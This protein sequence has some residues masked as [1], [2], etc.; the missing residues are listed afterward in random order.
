MQQQEPA[1]PPPPPEDEAL[2]VDYR[3]WASGAEVEVGR[4]LGR[5]SVQGAGLWVV[6]A[7]GGAGTSTWAGLL[8][9]GDAGRAW[10]VSAQRLR[11]LVAAR[12]SAAGLEAAR[13][14]AVEWVEGTLPHIE[15]VG[16]L[17]GAD[18]PGRRLPKA[19]QALVA[20]I[21]GAFPI[22]LR[23]PWQASWR[24]AIEPEVAAK[25]LRVRR[26]IRTVQ[27]INSEDQL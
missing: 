11:V 10:P 25:S 23:V 15:L 26:I 8:E 20:D 2:E 13:A 18:A 22:V 1:A 6:G 17:L 5:I 4:R 12:S 24:T 19:L 27:K 14:A 16:L 7:H 3:P 9:A 21:S